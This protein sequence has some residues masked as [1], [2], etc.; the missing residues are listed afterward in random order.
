MNDFNTVQ[1]G[2]NETISETGLVVL[3]SVGAVCNSSLNLLFIGLLNNL[4][5]RTSLIG[6]IRY[7]KKSKRCLLVY[8]LTEFR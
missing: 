3:V 5:Y 4:W 6:I 1:K 2:I 7:P 8:F